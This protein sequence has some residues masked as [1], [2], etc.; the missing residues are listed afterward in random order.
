MSQ[1]NT[2]KTGRTD[3]TDTQTKQAEMRKGRQTDR[4]P[5]RKADR[6]TDRQADKLLRILIYT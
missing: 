6:Q 1:A 3:K 5:A 4:Q 2:D